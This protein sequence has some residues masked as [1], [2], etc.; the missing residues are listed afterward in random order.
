M[1]GPIKKT[2]QNLITSQWS[3]DRCSTSFFYNENSW[4]Y[5]S[6]TREMER[7]K[8]ECLQ[9]QAQGTNI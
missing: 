5:G 6:H 3:V 9:A 8:K 7:W 1:Y 2:H 4:N